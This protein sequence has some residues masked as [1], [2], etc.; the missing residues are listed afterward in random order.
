MSQKEFRQSF[1]ELSENNKNNEVL[2]LSE[3]ELLSIVGGLAE[4]TQCGPI[5]PPPCEPVCS[6]T[7]PP[8]G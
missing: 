4:P 8:V 1:N 2:I 6:E 3:E 7:I 5:P